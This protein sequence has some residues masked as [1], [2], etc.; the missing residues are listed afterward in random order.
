MLKTCLKLDSKTSGNCL[1][2]NFI[3]MVEIM[4]EKMRF[5]A[6]FVVEH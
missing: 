1:N 6:G 4:A 5:H 2:Y 3:D